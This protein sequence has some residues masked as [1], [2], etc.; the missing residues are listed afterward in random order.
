M[1]FSDCFRCCG[2]FTCE[3]SLQRRVVLI[4][5]QKP[6]EA[7]LS[8]HAANVHLAATTWRAWGKPGIQSGGDCSWLQGPSFPMEAT[9][10]ARDPKCG[11]WEVLVLLLFLLYA[12][13]HWALSSLPGCCLAWLSS[14]WLPLSSPHPPLGWLRL[15]LS[16]WF[17]R[18]LLML[19]SDHTFRLL[20][21]KSILS[22]PAHGTQHP[23]NPHQLC[24]HWVIW[25]EGGHG[26]VSSPSSVLFASTPMQTSNLT[27]THGNTWRRIWKPSSQATGSFTPFCP[28]P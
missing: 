25:L 28:S 10:P 11:R 14:V 2:L 27:G 17:I 1:E 15:A 18:H 24:G 20:M 3:V 23:L 22:G 19:I 12:L 16:E 4:P 26:G 13:W 21:S 6:L 8:S 7:E 9:E 5:P